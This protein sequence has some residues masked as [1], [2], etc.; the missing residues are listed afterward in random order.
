M[1]KEELYKQ[2]Y[3]YHYGK[4]DYVKAE[5]LYCSIISEYPD[6]VEAGYAKSQLE[7]ISKDKVCVKVTNPFVGDADSLKI[8]EIILTTTPSI[9]GY[10][11][12]STIDVITAE[13]VFGM[14]IFK[15]MFASLSDIFGGRSK[16]TQ[17]I[18]REARVKCL[19]ELRK[20]ALELGANAIIGV[21]LDYSEFS[22]QGKSMLFLVASGTAVVIKKKEIINSTL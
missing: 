15:D 13:C 21:D 17:N 16:S 7:N 6:S 12:I 9:A 5:E 2:A 4:A 1:T 20:E 8:N 10:E 11:V 19:N 3:D 18:L 22:G 14:N